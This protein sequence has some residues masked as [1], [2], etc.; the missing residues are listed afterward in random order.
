MDTHGFLMHTDVHVYIM[1]V[2]PHTPLLLIHNANADR[3]ANLDTRQI[4]ERDEIEMKCHKRV[5][6]PIIHGGGITSSLNTSA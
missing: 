1:I 2:Y 5:T 6:L 3:L 4:N